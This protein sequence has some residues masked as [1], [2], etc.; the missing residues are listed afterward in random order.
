MRFFCLLLA[1]TAFTAVTTNA[2]VGY[3]P[4]IGLNIS[5][6]TGKSN[7]KDINASPKNGGMFGGIAE[8]ELTDHLFLLPGLFYYRNGYEKPFA[9]GNMTVAINSF[10]VPLNIE[11]KFGPPRRV[12]FF[13]GAGPYV[14]VNQG[15]AVIVSAYPVYSTYDI[16]IGNGATDDIRRWDVGLSGWGVYQITRG[17]FFRL[18]YQHGLLNMQPQHDANNSLV[19]YS[20]SISAGYVFPG[21]LRA[22]EEPKIQEDKAERKEREKR[23]E[24]LEKKRAENTK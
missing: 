1:S 17:L 24:R 21:D 2:Q 22:K 20:I 11:Y 12:K 5:N 6:F 16:R 14:T 23:K 3:G 18:R 15:G 4:E 10:E 9:G 8:V 19:N 7:G 13:V